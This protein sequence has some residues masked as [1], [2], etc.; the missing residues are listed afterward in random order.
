MV[1]G[2]SI[3]KASTKMKNKQVKIEYFMRLVR[4]RL[5]VIFMTES[6]DFYSEKVTTFHICLCNP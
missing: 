4:N 5:L 2:A 1:F 3:G 6:C